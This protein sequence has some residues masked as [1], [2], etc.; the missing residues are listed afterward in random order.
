MATPIPAKDVGRVVF[1]ELR[2]FVAREF[3]HATERERERI[4]AQFLN[5]WSRQQFG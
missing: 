2:E 4:L 3:A 5:A 1:E